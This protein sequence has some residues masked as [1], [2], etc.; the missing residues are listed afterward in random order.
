[1]AR[2][3]LLRNSIAPNGGRY[4]A[5]LPIKPL[6]MCAEAWPAAF[7]FWFTAR[8]RLMR[9]NGISRTETLGE[10]GRATWLMPAF[11]LCFAA[12]LLA[13]MLAA[14]AEPLV[15]EKDELKFGFIK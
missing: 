4:E 6:R 2:F 8:G 9:T 3:L 13:S 5:K 10:Q 11:T 1:M 7:L 15:P 14:R 12:M